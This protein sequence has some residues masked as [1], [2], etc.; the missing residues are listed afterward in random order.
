MGIRSTDVVMLTL[1]LSCVMPC[2][3]KVYTVGDSAGWSLSVDYTTWTTGKTFK[4]GDSLVF[5]Y[6]SSHSVDEVSSDDYGTCTVGNSIASYTSSP[7]TIILNTTGTHYFIC[8]VPGHCSGGMK[9]SVPVTGGGASPTPSTGA[10]PTTK[11]TPTPPTATST[12]SAVPA[13]SSAISPVVAVV[14][15]LVS[16]V[17]KFVLS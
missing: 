5:N 11:P 7:A 4:P 6:G 1:F 12:G 14:F 9:V 8:G 13:S 2:L 17:F 10:S 16:M 15:S 3:A